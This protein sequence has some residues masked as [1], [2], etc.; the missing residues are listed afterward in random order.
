MGSKKSTR[1][2][3][4]AGAGDRSNKKVEQGVAFVKKKIGFNQT[5][6]PT[7]GIVDSYALKSKKGGKGM[8]G[9]EASDST[10][11]YLVSIGEAKVGN[12]F[13]QVG[14]EHIRLSKS[15][16]E[17]LY[18]SGDASVSRSYMLTSKGREMKY[19]KS[20]GAMGS[21]DKSGIMGSV[22]ISE[23]M[24]E[25]QKKFKTIVVGALSLAVP[26]IG[27]SLMRSAAYDA[28]KSTYGNYR[29]RFNENMSDPNFASSNQASSVQSSSDLSASNK[30]MGNVNP[31]KETASTKFTKNIGR[32]FSDPNAKK[33][34]LFQTV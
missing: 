16:G 28:S 8:Y 32:S 24:F 3:S 2:N 25:S 18:K 20:G 33:R 4:N 11:N 22:P 27:G 6:H 1:S 31:E 30:A 26:G 7:E 19:G 34:S 13:K 29:S 15:E 5:K 21:G 23:Q 10:N 14:G 9:S 17:K 12:Y